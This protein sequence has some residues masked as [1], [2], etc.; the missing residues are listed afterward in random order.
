MLSEADLDQIM[1]IESNSFS[2][3]WPR[4]AF[5]LALSATAVFCLVAG[6]SDTV[7]G[8]IIGCRQGGTCL[9][10][11]LAVHPDHRRRGIASQL[12]GATIEMAEQQG[13]TRCRLEVRISNRAA[14]NLYRKHG[15]R[16]F[17]VQASYYS[18][19]EE[20]ALTMTRRRSRAE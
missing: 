7:C 10:A 13:A 12:L 15:F 6:R 18:S 16:P 9:V 2:S 1:T 8:Y 20:D 5:D 11:N 17:A 14:I 19:P 3:P 4:S